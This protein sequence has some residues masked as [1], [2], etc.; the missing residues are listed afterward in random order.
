MGP[1]ASESTA[2]TT[3]ERLLPVERLC[4]PQGA[5]E[6]FEGEQPTPEGARRPGRR[7]LRLAPEAAGDNPD[8]AV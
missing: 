3:G 7:L 5:G 1:T 6:V 4:N 2:E 8:T